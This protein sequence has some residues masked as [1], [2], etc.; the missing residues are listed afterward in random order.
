MK[1]VSEHSDVSV[2]VGIQG[3]ININNDPTTE[4]LNELVLVNYNGLEANATHNIFK[5]LSTINDQE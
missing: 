5:M 3:L 1:F 2:K 4:D